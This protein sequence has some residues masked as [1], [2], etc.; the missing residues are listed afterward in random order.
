M[1]AL[2][3]GKNL[4]E[5]CSMKE[6]NH[7]NALAEVFTYPKLDRNAFIGTWRETVKTSVP[8]MAYKLEAFIEHIQQKTVA[9]Q[10]EYYIATFDV[11]A[12]C[13]LDIGYVLYGE[14]YNRGIFMLNMKREQKK[15]DNDCGWELPDHLPNILTLLPKIEDE[16][17]IEELIFS[18]LAPALEK[19][20]EAFN[21]EDNVYKGMLEILLGIMESDY[22]ESEFE[23]FSF[24]SREKARSFECLP[25][26]KKI[27]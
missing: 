8:E 26:W 21:S 24:N 1:P 18:I 25:Q 4:H 17:F 10:Q 27:K 7:Y 19:M 5:D 11:Q 15:H 3:L 20:I 9:A 13:Y 12:L 14:D 6:L 16:T 2:G 22:P 23:R